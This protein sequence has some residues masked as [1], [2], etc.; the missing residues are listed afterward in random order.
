VELENQ[1]KRAMLIE[2]QKDQREK[3]I[4]KI[5]LVRENGAENVNISEKDR[6]LKDIN[7]RANQLADKYKYKADIVGAKDVKDYVKPNPSHF[8]PSGSPVI[9]L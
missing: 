8:K 1:K 5:R 9:N 2:L 3:E 6:I 4:N 7:N